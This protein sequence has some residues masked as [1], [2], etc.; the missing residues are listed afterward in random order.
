MRVSSTSADFEHSVLASRLNSW[1]R[2]SKRRPTAPPSA[3][4]AR[5]AAIWAVEPVDLLAH[6]GLGDQQ[7]RL[8]REPL[9]GQRR[10]RVEQRRDEL[11]ASRARSAAG[12]AA[13]PMLRG[14]DE[15]GDLAEPRR[16]APRRGARLP[17]PAPLAEARQRLVASS[18]AAAA[19]RRSRVSSS[20]GSLASLDH[21]AHGQQPVERAAAPPRARPRG[22][23]PS[24]SIC[25]SSAARLTLSAAGARAARQRQRRRDRSRASAA[26]ASSARSGSSSASKP[27][28]RRKRRSS[29]LAV[30]AL[31]LPHP[32]QSLAWPSAR[33]NPVMLET[34]MAPLY[35]CGA[36]R[37]NA[38]SASARDRCS[39][40]RARR[41]SATLRLCSASVAAKLCRPCRRRRNTA[42]R[43]RSGASAARDRGHARIVDRRRRQALRRD[44]CC[45]GD[46]MARSCVVER[47]GERRAP[48][49]V[50]A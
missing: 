38:Y 49:W 45:S 23:A 7:R 19:S 39:A 48:P 29:A 5:A 35:P 9:L 30:D 44:R 37:E 15:L 18:A 36:A 11:R 31:H 43:A 2:K 26:P 33:A 47:M 28:G 32:G 3:S 25:G 17:R 12:C 16:R 50:S 4:S 46:S 20:A 10:R 21:A 14:R 40:L 13:A 42:R 1:Q 8:L 6:V 27:G 41:S 34:A 24:A 22:R